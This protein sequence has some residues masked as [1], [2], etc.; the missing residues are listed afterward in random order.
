LFDHAGAVRAGDVG[1]AVGAAAVDHDDLIGK[2]HGLQAFGQPRRRVSGDDGDA[3]G[4][5]LHT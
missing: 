4:G 2:G 3:E 5:F 1:G